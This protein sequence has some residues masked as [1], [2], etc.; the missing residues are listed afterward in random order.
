[1]FVQML[2]QEICAWFRKFLS[3][4][5]FYTCEDSKNAPITTRTTKPLLGSLHDAR[6]QRTATFSKLNKITI[7]PQCEKGFGFH[8]TQISIWK[9]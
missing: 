5:F 6:G 3:T 9:F 2:S 1:M 4:N 8:P 7:Q